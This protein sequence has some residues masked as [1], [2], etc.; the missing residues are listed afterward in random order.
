MNEYISNLEIQQELNELEEF[1]VKS[2]ED[3]FD[4]IKVK[5][6]IEYDLVDDKLIGV[7]IGSNDRVYQFYISQEEGVTSMTRMI[8][9]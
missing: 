6:F 8:G 5:A 1:M 2:I 9:E 7:I 3:D 4:P